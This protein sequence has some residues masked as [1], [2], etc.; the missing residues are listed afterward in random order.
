MDLFK[1]RNFALIALT[2]FAVLA[3]PLLGHGSV[4]AEYD[5]YKVELR[6]LEEDASKS[7]LR[8]YWLN[9][10]DKFDRLYKNNP[11]W[12]N[13]AAALF[14]AAEAYDA[15]AQRSYAN[16]DRKLAIDFY[17]KV[18][19]EFP[20]SV[21]ADDALFNIARVYNEQLKNSARASEYLDIIEKKYPNTD[22]AP[23]AREYAKTMGQTITASL[24]TNLESL[25]AP[26]EPNGRV[27]YQGLRAQQKGDIIQ[28]RVALNASERKNNLV[29]WSLDYKAP[30]QA[31]NS[32]ARL[33]LTL[34]D[35]T[36]QADTLAGH[37]YINMGI[38]S[39]YVIDYSK[40]NSTTIIIDFEELAAYYAYYDKASSSIVIETT[41]KSNRLS[42]GVITKTVTSNAKGQDFL[43]RDFALK[44][45]IDIKTIII[46]AG[47]GGK[48]PG[49]V[50]NG[51]LEKDIALEVALIL[52]AKL[53]EMGYNIEYTRKNDT[54]LSL[55]QRA[56]I[57]EDRKGD[58]FISVH[59]NAAENPNISGIETYYL[60][61]SK[62]PGNEHL[63]HR[64]KSGTIKNYRMGELDS[65]LDEL[66]FR[67][68]RFESE[69][70][71]S[72]VQ[73]NMYGHV[74]RRGFE[75]Q[76]GGT[77]GSVFSVLENTHMPGVLL[78]VGYMSNVYDARNLKNKAYINSIADGIARGI[79]SYAEDLN[80]ARN[81]L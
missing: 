46:D 37:K 44:M 19:A 67:T 48:D 76:N 55:S 11:T 61:Y 77:K 64:E 41:N 14:R 34:S 71:A 39:R 6:R 58:M 52:G 9:L 69:R 68:L 4:E 27:I 28:L 53:E 5:K 43:S 73:T 32:P 56:A 2:L 18:Y 10:A 38:L 20:N 50:H 35:T 59:A 36:A 75:V 17:E 54:F 1:V 29:T 49:A 26:A 72:F 13:R 62:D 63:G 40:R 15:L 12:P 21:L 47:H 25:K 57:A 23:K 7:Q 60:D 74:N 31:T 80:L 42:K 79:N 78:E 33:I 51:M 8:H 22:H 70:L 3:L 30:Q 16:Q 24:N 66:A 81:G 65:A 45:G